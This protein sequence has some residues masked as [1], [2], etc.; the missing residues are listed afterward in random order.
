[1][2]DFPLKL[3]VITNVYNEEYFLPFWLEHHKKIF[4]HGVVFDW[5]SSDSSMDI[6][7]KMCPT[8][9]II[10]SPLKLFDAY[11]NDILIMNEEVKHDG[12]KMVLNTTEFLV[13]PKPIRELLS[14]ERNSYYMRVVP[15]VL[16]T[17]ATQD[18]QN[19]KELFENI[20]RVCIGG[21]PI[22]ERASRC[23]H[24][25]DHGHYSLGR[26]L[27]TLPLTGDLPFYVLWFGFYPW[28]EKFHARKLQIK[29]K[30]PQ[31]DYEKGFS[32]QHKESREG[33]E[34]RREKALELS[35]SIESV[36]HLEECLLH[37]IRCWEEGERVKI[38]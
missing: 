35:T 37:S 8:W 15:S 5:G 31:S 20:T 13:S 34:Y 10:P 32:H 30:I 4:D 33:N 22:T 14:S 16:S 3:T 27:Q 18:P 7:R 11:E 28:N 21:I 12:Y 24:S 29:D 23:I 19:L 36:P 25:W 1:M 6:I 17:H 38:N 26:H 2:T 9:E